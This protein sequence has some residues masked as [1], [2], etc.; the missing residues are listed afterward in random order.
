[1]NYAVILAGGAGTRLWPL[2]RER[3][4]KTALRF[5]SDQSMF[6]IAVARL[7]PLFTPDQII[8]VAGRDHADVLSQ[9]VP[10][11]PADN[12]VIEPEGR[13]TAPAIGLVAVHLAARDPEA[14]MAVLTADHH[15]GDTET[16]RR[17]ISAA[18]E[19]AQDDF[20]VTLGITPTEPSTQYGYIEQGQELATVDGFKV[21][22]TERFIEKP[23]QERAEDMLE[24]GNFSWNSGMFMWKVSAILQEFRLQM[25]LLYEALMRI[26]VT[27]KG[28]VSESANRAEYERVL[29]EVW[30]S[31]PRQSIDYGVME[32]ARKVAVIPVDMA[33]LDIGN[34]TSM[35]VLFDQDKAGNAVRGDALL[36]DS[37]NLMV[38]GGKRLIAVIGLEDLAIIDSDDALLIC[39]KDRVGDVRK[40]VA[41][42]K[43]SGRTDLI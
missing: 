32:M 2:S 9:Q 34:W 5:Y 38:V 27:L 29:S 17:A 42:L 31:I 12:F 39:P 24:Q 15:I 10:E 13:N 19:V 11:I 36:L 20:L 23:Q 28:S 43:E 37:R 1:M 14:H 6:Q 7:A 18:L 25:P 30:P 8:V 40:I 41:Q 16:F 4:P 26:S 21:Y 22:S 33:W 35:K 3:L